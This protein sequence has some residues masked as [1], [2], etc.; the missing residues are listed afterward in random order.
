MDQSE[1]STLN[2]S[3]NMFTSCA[4]RLGSG[5]TAP[6]TTINGNN[7]SGINMAQ[8][9]IFSASYNTDSSLLIE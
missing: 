2:L 5:A 8:V 9:T 7:F 1:A 3:G 4:V 6:H